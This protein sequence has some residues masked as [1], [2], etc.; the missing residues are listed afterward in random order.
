MKCKDCGVL[1]SCDEG[2]KIDE[3]EDE[4]GG[5]YY[6]CGTC[7]STGQAGALGSIIHWC[8]DMFGLVSGEP[9]ISDEDIVKAFKEVTE[10]QNH[11][12]TDQ[13]A[14]SDKNDS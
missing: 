6:S 5:H 4:A 8:Q 7:V 11:I 3:Y 13:Q 9:R 10:E 1:V 2:H 14:R 12:A